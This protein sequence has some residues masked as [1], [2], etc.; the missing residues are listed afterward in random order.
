MDNVLLALLVGMGVIPGETYT[1]DQLT[2]RL[3]KVSE[4]EPDIAQKALKNLVRRGALVKL[5]DD[6]YQQAQV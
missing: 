6:L 3:V 4:V 1:F 2:E 5:E